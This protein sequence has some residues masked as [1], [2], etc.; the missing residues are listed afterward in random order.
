MQSTHITYDNL[1][2]T[3]GVFT[4]LLRA[5]HRHFNERNDWDLPHARGMEFDQYDTPES[6]Y[7]AIHDDTSVKAGFRLTPTTAQSINASYMLRDAQLGLLPGLP[8][9]LL[10][11][12]APRDPDVWEITRV[13]ISDELL[14]HERKTVY[15]ELASNLASMATALQV[16]SF[17]CLTSVTAALLTLK[18]G[19]HMHPAGPKCEIAGELCQAYSLKLRHYPASMAAA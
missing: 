10:D 12:P 19:F 14:S 5:R 6:V 13:F 1:E 16:R 9:T 11:T 7:C 15:R 17:L 3:G 8:N 4:R 18:V 2:Q